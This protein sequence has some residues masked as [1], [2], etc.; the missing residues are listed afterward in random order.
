MLVA[1]DEKT[2]FLFVINA[3]I[4]EQIYAIVVA[5]IVE[6]ANFLHIKY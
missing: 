6:K 1:F 3:N 5:E 4:I 2:K